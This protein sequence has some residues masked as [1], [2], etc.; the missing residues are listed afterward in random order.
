M[1]FWRQTIF[2]ASGNNTIRQIV[3]AKKLLSCNYFILIYIN[4][5][6]ATW[7]HKQTNKQKKCTE[8]QNNTKEL[9]TRKINETEL[10]I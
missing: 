1:L 9:Y 2:N 7:Q 3:T 8:K 5:Y 10:H 6:F 4:L